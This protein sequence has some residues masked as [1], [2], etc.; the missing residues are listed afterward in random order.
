MRIKG[1]NASIGPDTQKALTAVRIAHCCPLSPGTV[2]ALLF[3]IAC[4]S[5]QVHAWV[6]KLFL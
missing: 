4:T 5:S 1:Y 3:P 6:T 2:Y